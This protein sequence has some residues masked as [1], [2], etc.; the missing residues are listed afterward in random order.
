[1]CAEDYYWVDIVTNN[2]DT[3]AS[4]LSMQP[5]YVTHHWKMLLPTNHKLRSDLLAKYKKDWN[6][7]SISAGLYLGGT[8]EF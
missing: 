1:M 4:R 6:L 5:I 2:I 3:E 7:R 8:Y